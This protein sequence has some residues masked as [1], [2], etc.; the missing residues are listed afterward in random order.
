[1]DR[2]EEHTCASLCV[3]WKAAGKFI[4]AVWAAKF[5]T[6]ETMSQRDILKRVGQYPSIPLICKECRT[7]E[8]QDSDEGRDQAAGWRG[9]QD[10]HQGKAAILHTLVGR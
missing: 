10:L 5:S 6:M 3:P 7:Q 8:D 9:L 2:S 4:G 1:M